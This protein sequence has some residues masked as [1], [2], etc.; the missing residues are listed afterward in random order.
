M[1]VPFEGPA[2]IAT[3]A[4]EGGHELAMVRLYDDQPLPPP[5][6]FDL[7]AI[8]GGPMSVH[9]EEAH[10]WLRDEKRYIEQSMGLGKKML[11]VCLGAQLL[12]DVLGAQVRPNTHAE[13][14]WH[15]VQL[16]DPGRQSALLDGWPDRFIAFHWHGETFDLP[17]GAVHLATS[18]ACHHQAFL[19]GQNVVGLQFHVEYSADSIEKMI[20]HCDHELRKGPYIQSAD[21]IRAGYNHLP[22]NQRLLRALLDN[23][24]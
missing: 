6:A 3:W 12:A 7:L 13:I 22:A 1:H 2:E 20:Q 5:E 17:A 4:A 10:P 14:G 11:G 18:D 15:E 23:F 24:N 8:M 9:D 16:T 19:C 21:L